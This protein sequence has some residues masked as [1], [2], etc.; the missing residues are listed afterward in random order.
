MLDCK[1][2]E[3]MI[4]EFLNDELDG[5]SMEKFIAHIENCPECM[6]ELSIQ[7][8][9]TEGMNRLE[10]GNTFELKKELD[11]L[12]EDDKDWIYMLRCKKMVRLVS[13][14][15]GI[16]TIAAILCMVIIL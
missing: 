14:L 15:I 9:I 13:Y 16:C 10:Q 1:E 5:N 3:K 11:I 2:Y 7:F 6:E 8:L 4:P 12:I